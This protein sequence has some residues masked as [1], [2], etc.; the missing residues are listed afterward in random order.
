MNFTIQ[1]AE[2][3]RYLSLN[4]MICGNL[5]PQYS[6]IPTL[7]AQKYIIIS[8]NQTKNTL[9]LIQTTPSLENQQ[10]KCERNQTTSE[11]GM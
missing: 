2:N 8:C 11:I 9:V 3:R 7:I 5:T 10:R 6:I 4:P 1:I